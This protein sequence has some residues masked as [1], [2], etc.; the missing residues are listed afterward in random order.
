MVSQGEEKGG[1]LEEFQNSGAYINMR[2]EP[3][4]LLFGQVLGG[5]FFEKSKLEE[6]LEG[7]GGVGWGVTLFSN[8]SMCLCNL[9]LAC[10]I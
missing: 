7:G 2:C 8:F 4:F 9:P 1:N 3:V 6:G 5:G 10:I